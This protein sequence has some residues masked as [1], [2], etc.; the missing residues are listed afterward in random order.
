MLKRFSASLKVDLN[1]KSFNQCSFYFTGL[2]LNGI[3][4]LECIGKEHAVVQILSSA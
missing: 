1:L 2:E 4:R 3:L